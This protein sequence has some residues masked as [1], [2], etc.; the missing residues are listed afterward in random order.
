MNITIR[1]TSAADLENVMDLWNNGEVMFYVGFPNGLGITLDQLERWL[2]NG[3]KNPFYQHFS[4][5][6][7]ELG[8]CGETCYDVDRA[9]DLASLDIKL[10][11]K[12]QG[13]G[14]AA[15]ALRYVI[16]QVFALDLATKAYVEPAPANQKAWQL[17]ERIGFVSKPR[18]AFLEA[19]ETYLEITKDLFQS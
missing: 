9:H 16:N 18:P 10:L 5:Y 4:I 15:Y 1:E 3:Q 11:P 19:D 6:T 13:K 12:A 14:I 8:Y 7:D 17:Y 2:E